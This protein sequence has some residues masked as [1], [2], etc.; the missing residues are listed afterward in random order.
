[1]L[2]TYI[3]SVKMLLAASLLAAAL[4]ATPAVAS[5]PGHAD[6]GRARFHGLFVNW[7]AASRDAVEAER[8]AAARP[9]P[10]PAAGSLGLDFPIFPR[11]ALLS[12]PGF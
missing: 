5:Q 4:A 10:A 8:Q 6:V 12:L 7:N 2:F 9:A 3:A 11:P 1:M